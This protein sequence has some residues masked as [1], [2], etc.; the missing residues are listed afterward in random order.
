MWAMSRAEAAIKRSEGRPATRAGGLPALIEPM[1]ATP[2]AEPFDSPTHVFEVKWDGVRALLFIED[3][4][5]RVQDRFLRD[6]TRLY[7]ELQSAAARVNEGPVVLDGEIMVLDEEGWPDA[8]KLRERLAAK[9]ETEALALSERLPV[10]FQAF[11]ILYRGGRPVMDFPLSRRKKLLEGTVRTNAHIGVPVFLEREG[12]AFFEAARQHGLEGVIA[13]EMDS[14][15]RP[16]ERS[17]EW[18]SVKVHQRDEFVVGGFTFGG[19]PRDLKPRVREPFGSLLLGLY[20]D[21]D[22]L[23]YVGEVAGGFSEEATE[24]AMDRLDELLSSACPF[25]EAPASQR[26]QFWCRPELVATV[27]FAG[28]APDGTLRFPVFEALRPDVPPEACRLD[29]STLGG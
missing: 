24:E 21:E 25:A 1:L 19:R 14:H 5:V 26:L 15:Y 6:V 17:G 13:K 23:H 9:D 3:N 27:R 12:V 10:T 16:G 11:D 22:G 18:L 29:G 4:K 20:D 28:W 8:R 7:P 2:C